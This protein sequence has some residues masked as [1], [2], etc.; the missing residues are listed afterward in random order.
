M[1]HTV[2]LLASEAQRPAL[3]CLW[4]ADEPARVGEM[5]PRPPATVVVGRDESSNMVRQRPGKAHYTGPIQSLRVS[6]RQLRLTHAADHILLSSEGRCPVLVNGVRVQ[7]ARL[8]VGD[9]VYLER[10]ML[11]AVCARP[12]ELSETSLEPG[13]FGQPDADGLVGESPAMWALRSAIARAAASDRPVR[14]TGHLGDERALVAQAIGRQRPDMPQPSIGVGGLPNEQVVA[15]PPLEE[16]LEDVPLLVRASL[17]RRLV[18]QPE[19][20]RFF[21]AARAFPRIAPERVMAA[22]TGATTVE[23]L[24][25][26]VARWITES[27]GDQLV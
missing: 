21:D 13:P 1:P 24:E 23:A 7:Q 4:A 22:V 11:F 16:R 14:V 15:V 10:Q 2:C 25:A 17:Y 27:P 26:K 5:V 8:V 6:R 9:R 20:A 3:V 19:L 12:S 18:E